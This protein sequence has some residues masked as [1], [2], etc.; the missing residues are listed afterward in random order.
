[1]RR[2]KRKKRKGILFSYRRRYRRLHP[3]VKFMCLHTLGSASGRLVR[4]LAFV[5]LVSSTRNRVS[6]SMPSHFSYAYRVPALPIFTSRMWQLV[7]LLRKRRV[8]DT[9]N[10]LPSTSSSCYRL[11]LCDVVDNEYQSTTAFFQNYVHS[12]RCRNLLLMR[13]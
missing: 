6:S 10:S 3:I 7:G 4:V 8:P 5:I 9:H 11:S 2:W 12:T 1:M 13:R